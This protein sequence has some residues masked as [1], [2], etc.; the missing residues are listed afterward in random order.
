MIQ[1][2]FCVIVKN[3]VCYTSYCKDQ[4]ITVADCHIVP[5]YL[6][7]GTVRDTKLVAASGKSCFGNPKLPLSS[8]EEYSAPGTP[9]YNP[10]VKKWCTKSMGLVSTG[11]SSSSSTEYDLPSPVVTPQLSPQPSDTEPEDVPEPPKAPCG[12][13]RKPKIKVVRK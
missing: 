8:G 10:A 4:E 7:S 5:V 1:K 9:V 11:E 6:G 3:S 2:H 13:P 12:W